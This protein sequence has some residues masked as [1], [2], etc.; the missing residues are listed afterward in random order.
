[1]NCLHC[2]TELTKVANHTIDEFLHS[3][4]KDRFSSVTYLTCSKCNSGVQV[5][6][7]KKEHEKSNYYKGYHSEYMKLFS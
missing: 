5:F 1:M 4:M 3:N 2:Q 6:E 7:P